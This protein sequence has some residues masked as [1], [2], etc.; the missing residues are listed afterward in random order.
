MATASN[1]RILR[2]IRL[3]IAICLLS[4]PA[5]AKYGGGSGTAEDPYQI[6]TAEQMNTIGAEPNDWDKHFKLMANISL[7]A[8]SG[9]SFNII[10]TRERPFTGVFDGNARTVSNLRYH[11]NALSN[12]GL[13]GCIDGRNVEIKDLGLIG[14]NVDA[15]K[16]QCVGS[17]VGYLQCG[18]MVKCY[19]KGGSVAGYDG[20]GGLVG[21]AGA[22]TIA[23]CCVER[24]TVSGRGF[25]GGLVGESVNSSITNCYSDCNVPGK[26]N[27]GG[28]V[29]YN[30]WGNT[31]TNC[32]SVG[33]VMG[34]SRVGGLVGYSLGPV[35]DSFWDIQT[36]GQTTS[37]SGTGKATAEMQQARTFL[38]A[39]WDFVDETE[40]GTHDIWFILEDQDYPRF[41]YEL[42]QTRYGGG[43][44]TAEDPY[45]IATTADL[46][47]LGETPEDYDKHFLLTANID[48]DPNLLGGWVF[49]KAVIAPDTDPAISGFQGTF[50]TGLFEGNRHTISHLTVVGEDYVGLFGRLWSGGEIK[51]LGVVDAN[52]SGSGSYVGGLA[53][54]NWGHVTRC[55]STSTVSG[56]IW[57]VGG[58]VGFNAGNVTHCYSIGAV[59]GNDEVG[60]LVGQNAEF[61]T[62]SNCY[63]TGAVTG[64]GKYVGGLV[65]YN[66]GDVT[67]SFWD[68]QTSGEA[69]SAGGTGKTTAEMQNIQTYLYAGWD[70][71]GEIENG[72]HETWQ[73]PQGGGYPVLAMF[74]GYTP[75]QLQG[76]GTPDE[77]YLISDPAELG[78]MVYYSPYSHYRLTASLDLSGIRWGTAI[79]PSFRGTFDGNN[80]TISHLTV[81]G[82][83]YLGLFG[84]LAF[85]AE[86]KGLAVVDV[87]LTASGDYVGGLAGR[88][89]GN[90][91]RCYGTG[92]VSGRYLIGGLVGD[93]S[94]PV[95]DCYSTAAVSGTSG[96]GGL[97]GSNGGD[98]TRCYS[99]GAVRGESEVG[100]LLGSNWFTVTGCFWDIQTSGQATSAS[101]TGKTTAEMHD[102]QTFQDAGWDFA[103]EIKDGLHEIWRMPQEGGYPVLSVF[104]GYT[105]PQL[106]GSGAADDPYLISD[107]LELG[108]MYYYSPSAHYSLAAPIDLAGIRWGT[109]VIPRFGGTFDGDNQTISHLTIQGQSYLGLFGYLGSGAEVENLG[110]VDVKITGSGDSVGGLVGS[111]SSWDTAGGNV[112]QCYSSGAV[113]GDYYVGG[114]VGYN[115]GRM[116]SCYSTAAVSG[117]SGVGG[118]VGS[119]GGD[120]TRCYSTGAVTGSKWVGGLVG[121]NSRG[122][123]AQSF[124]DIKASGQAGSWGGT[125]KTT[126]E[127]QTASTFLEAG[128]DFVGEMDNGTENIWAICE[129][130]DYPKLAWQFLIADFNG[131]GHTD[132]VDF[133]I[134][135]Q[136]WLGS[137]SSFWCGG[138]TDLTNDGSVDFA[139]LMVLAENWLTD[140]SHR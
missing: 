90:L 21:V 44:G 128:W 114:L 94:G 125:G 131:D 109:A 110:L 100:G 77:P 53:G 10:G 42:S 11:S 60:G 1:S 34:T 7:G 133:C 86:V 29:G 49:H 45:Q 115:L 5:Y 73:M 79:I 19:A 27:V 22:A 8:Y 72:T 38:D 102:I 17:L 58:L 47:A 124:W 132:F 139:D 116:T 48:L 37:A 20:V 4:F 3:L 97:V 15:G 135:G 24:G 26:E 30:S 98:V 119:N 39:G 57:N 121:C 78:A 105:P 89:G 66:D 51:A 12:I 118:L 106:Q 9:T 56:S 71:V 85:G 63:S 83:S 107:A 69:T 36:S 123:M 59:S 117:T 112:T 127:M 113:S 61:S 52:I 126:G 67:G 43:S 136:R 137:D 31:I 41:W 130:V 82:V 75:P 18:N 40:N 70:L 99:T 92:A 35:R 91:I 95:S 93:N 54:D 6:W 108:A 25:V 84:E 81:T 111:N 62:V 64:T 101:G 138:G 122:A 140:I 96:I 50:F 87:N 134:F 80:L 16:G 129:G 32:Y 88:N 14:P 76:L 74:S 13:F 28:L 65:G 120:M 104:N 46:I 103:G 2:T 68:I 23:Y 33:P 55:Y